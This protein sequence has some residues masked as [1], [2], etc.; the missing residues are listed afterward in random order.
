MNSNP[1][2]S[3]LLLSSKTPKK[4]YFGTTLVE[5]SSTEKMLGTQIDSTLL[6]TSIFLLYIAK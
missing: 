3:H 6:L 2:K 4:A 1:E 5:S